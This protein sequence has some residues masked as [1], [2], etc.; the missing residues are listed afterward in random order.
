MT[1][2]GMSGRLD[3]TGKKGWQWRNRSKSAKTRVCRKQFLEF[4]N[5][6]EKDIEQNSRGKQKKKKKS[7]NY[8][9]W[10]WTVSENTAVEVLHSSWYCLFS[11]YWKV[12][13]PNIYLCKKNIRSCSTGQKRQ[14]IPGPI[15]RHGVISMTMGIHIHCYLGLTPRD[16][17]KHPLILWSPYYTIPVPWVKP[18]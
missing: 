15:K 10:I 4:P 8:V 14:K 13:L 5:L 17:V 12:K 3:A 7:T 9:K 11:K 18:F 16:I 2:R 1:V 6:A